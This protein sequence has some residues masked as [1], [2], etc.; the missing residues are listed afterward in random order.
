MQILPNLDF[1][2]Y[3]GGHVW[4]LDWCPRVHQKSDCDIKCEYL[5]VSAHPP[6][7]SY[8]KIGA[9]LTG[10]G[11]IQ[12]WCVLNVSGKE[13][14]L[15]PL[16]KKKGKQGR[17]RKQ[18]VTDES[19]SLVKKP[20]GRPRKTTITKP[21]KKAR[22]R[23]RKT[24]IIEDLSLSEDS[25][26]VFLDS[27]TDEETDQASPPL[28]NRRGRQ[29]KEAVIGE[30]V[31][32]VDS[33][34]QI[35]QALANQTENPT[36]ETAPP[37]KVYQRAKWR[38][39]KKPV[40]K[41]S[42]KNLDG[43]NQIAGALTDQIEKGTDI[44][45]LPLNKTKITSS[46]LNKTKRK[47]RKKTSSP[48]NKTKRKL[49]KKTV[50]EDSI[51]DL[52]SSSMLSLA[53]IPSDKGSQGT[54]RT[55]PPKT[56]I[57]LRS[58]RTRSRTS[59]NLAREKISALTSDDELL[60]E[61]PGIFTNFG[62]KMHNDGEAELKSAETDIELKNEAQE[63]CDLLI[64]TFRKKRKRKEKG[65]DEISIEG[66]RSTETAKLTEGQADKSPLPVLPASGDCG[67]H[68][69]ALNQIEVADGCLD[70]NK[71]DFQLPTDVLLPR[72]VL[73]LAHNGKVAWDVKWRPLNVDFESSE[74]M[75]RMGYLAV[76]LGN[77]SL[78]VWEVPSPSKIKALYA[79]YQTDCT[80]PRFVKLAPVFKCSELKTG[81]R[82]SIPL[83][84]EWSRASPHD[85][86]VAGCHD[87]TV[88]LWKFSPTGSPIDTKPLL[89]F[90]A[91]NAPIRS[92]AWA[93]CGS[94]AE[95][96][97]VIAT[98]GHG[99]LRFWDLRDPYRPLWDL[100][101]MRRTIYSVDWLP[102]PR[103]VIMSFDDGTLRILSLLKSANDVPVTG[104]PYAG[105][106]QQGL[107]S[108][109][110][111]SFPVWSVQASRLTG[112]VAYCSADGYVVHFQLTE[113]AVDKD[114]S[115]NKA[116]HF[117]CGSLTDEDA[118]VA[119]NTPLPGLPFPLKKS[120]N[121]WGDTPR[122]TRGFSS[123]FN[124][125]KKAKGQPTSDDTRLVLWEAD[126]TS[127]CASELL[128]DSQKGKSIPKTK[129]SK[130]KTST[131]DLTLAIREEAAENSDGGEK[132]Q[133]EEKEMEIDVFPSKIVAL[134]RVR[135]NMN[136][137]SERW[138]CY[139]GAAGI[140]RCQ[141][142]STRFL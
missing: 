126:D 137:G 37:L 16:T 109:F 86:I 66:I 101:P 60:D 6:E 4:A 83:T 102:D 33:D 40:S 89:R 41:E 25:D 93:P 85:L 98:A 70:S 62:A 19:P 79:S 29:K 46:P 76:L 38:M 15:P 31:A 68:S 71:P 84:L 107:H 56:R 13:E 32:G 134:H 105:T 12:I 116:P 22:G 35:T 43:N 11:V 17:P 122:S 73:C 96:V 77:G 54:D 26:E 82:Q 121:E 2:L 139:G 3:V 100:N 74:D 118:A 48:L 44:T 127:N 34:S 95:S 106:Q 117:L 69:T 50:T 142:I 99:G 36:V 27:E 53:L 119:V 110:C 120:L 59:N 9:T 87:G 57:K 14:D 55:S 115:R 20:R 91:D 8:H 88:A 72:L 75:R 97:N 65:R 114:P 92:L 63:D 128:V 23:P 67:Q 133:K 45:S 64:N 136:K 5:A 135:W 28:R 132:N 7:S 24:P 52:D 108:L 129:A 39:D 123:D 125:A 94:D 80:D 42:V 18:I 90:S 58:R 113:K 61:P 141:E 10:R 104:K 21:L 51:G 81:D 49:R 131:A 124:H 112:I 78:E 140:V 1:V 111:S 103:C 130:K 138:L 47:L 30:S